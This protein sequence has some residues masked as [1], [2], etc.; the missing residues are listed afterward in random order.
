MIQ[1]KLNEAFM[2]L[3]IFSIENNKVT[4]S[5]TIN[6]VIVNGTMEKKAKPLH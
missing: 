3:S 5:N 1:Y 4:V 2:G 6:E